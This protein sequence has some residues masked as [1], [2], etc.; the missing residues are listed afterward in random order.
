MTDISTTFL[1]NQEL[2]VHRWFR[3]SAGFSAAW[4]S[5]EVAERCRRG[6]S[7]VFD[8][9]AGSGTTV[10]AAQQLGVRAVGLE[11]HPFV[12]RVANAKLKW[13]SD[14]ELFL[15]TATRILE[16]A[17]RAPIRRGKSESPLLEK[18]YEPATLDD[19]GRLSR[20]LATAR[21]K[22]RPE[23]ELCWLA[24]VSILRVCSKV[25]TAPWQYVLPKKRKARAWE[26]F[27]AFRTQIEKMAADM[28]SA[29]SA[30]E[31]VAP[32]EILA[33][34]ARNCSAIE[35]GSVD[36]V[37]TSPPYPNN[38]DYADATR[39][40]MSFFGEV[41]R[42]ADLHEA[43]RQYLLPSCS[44]HMQREKLSLDTWLA[45][46][47][48]EPIR[49]ELSSACHELAELRGQRAG[50]KSYDTMVAAYFAGMA[51]TIAAL[52]RVVAPGGALCFVVGDSAPYGVHLPVE[53][54]L[55]TLAEST[56]FESPVFEE[57]RK[58]NTKWLNRKH[59]VPLHEGR[60]WLS[61]KRLHR[62][63]R[64]RVT[65]SEKTQSGR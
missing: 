10:I 60:L 6:K 22:E 48:L 20:A 65:I 12:H 39:V 7:V 19:L 31:L 46:R 18:I 21:N 29:Q 27:L 34:D 13:V 49:E 58:R 26:P 16:R 8:P 63:T 36:L 1:P 52:G 57:T 24:L 17:E 3:Y 64:N 28:R 4:V 51:E 53:R 44:Q 41:E 30:A 11:A 33:G 37:L 14:V 23:H 42:W 2:P 5:R 55:A 25:N 9:F 32:A 38:Y 50:K 59:R 43:V 61:K 56:G 35:D 47:G 15:R 62:Y 45:H 40:E 54:W